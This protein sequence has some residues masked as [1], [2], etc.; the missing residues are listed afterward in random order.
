M[1]Y[2][3]DIDLQNAL[4]A[5]SDGQFIPSNTQFDTW[6]KKA[7]T[8]QDQRVIDKDCEL[9]IRLVDATE[10]HS[11]NHEYRDKAKPTNVLSFPSD[12]PDF[13]IES[14]ATYYLGDLIVCSS[15]LSKEAAEQNKK[16]ENHWAHICI[17]GLLHLLGYDHINENEAVHMEA[18]ETKI[19]AE[20][21]IDDPYKDI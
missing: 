13:I 9:T 15:V 11:I 7:L 8:L 19:L 16:L 20:L 21:G 12:L 4:S 5:E 18:L 6:F 3:I 10:S 2:R 17:H 1:T 14:E